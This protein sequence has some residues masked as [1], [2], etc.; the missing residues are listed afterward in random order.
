MGVRIRGLSART[1]DLIHTM[2]I[3]G[4]AHCTLQTFLLVLIYVID[5]C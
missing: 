5:T 1:L 2:I 4:K 3:H